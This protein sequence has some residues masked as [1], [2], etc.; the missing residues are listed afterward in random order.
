LKL[1]KDTLQLDLIVQNPGKTEAI[2]NKIAV[3]CN[4]DG[5]HIG[6]INY[7]GKIKIAARSKEN[8]SGVTTIKNLKARLTNG[9]FIVSS[10]LDYF[11]HDDEAKN[12]VLK[13]D[14]RLT[15]SGLNYPFKQDLPFKI[16][17][18]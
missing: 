18:K 7:E 8:P 10:I 12:K 11:G 15:A 1:N 4:L 2:L 13:L 5:N 6:D 9:L 3:A 17:K 14:G 16:N